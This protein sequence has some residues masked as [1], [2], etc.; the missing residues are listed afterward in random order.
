MR[1]GEEKII[2]IQNLYYILCYA[3][4]LAEQR[5]KLK[6]DAKHCDTYPDLYAKLLTAGCSRLLKFG[7]YNEYVN[8][9]EARYG[10]KGKLNVSETIKMGNWK[11]GKLNCIYDEYSHDVV[12]NQI[13]YATL[14]FLM[15]YDKLD[16]ANHKA[17][18]QIYRSFP[19]VRRIELSHE[20]FDKV[21]IN[22]NNRFY[23]L[24]IQICKI[25]FESLLPDANQK[26]HYSFVDFSTD[27][28]NRIFENFL[29]SVH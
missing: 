24:L 16:P 18:S 27:K 5:G 17:I 6:V 14:R 1:K 3:W 11:E 26:G 19:H 21:S 13:I 10:V 20:V 25:I 8:I 22:R 28:M 9:Q 12:A 23:G 15:S 7:L 2:P 29:L 4:G